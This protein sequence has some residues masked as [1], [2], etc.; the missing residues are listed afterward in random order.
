M[1]PESRLKNTQQSRPSGEDIQPESSAAGPVPEPQPEIRIGKALVPAEVD[2]RDSTVML[3]TMSLGEESIYLAPQKTWSQLDV[4]KWRVQGKL[5]GTPAGLEIT[6]DYVKVGGETVSISEP[7]GAEKL[8]RVFAK[9]MASE[10]EASELAK[11]KARTSARPLDAAPQEEDQIRFQVEMDKNGQ[12]RI[13]CLEGKDMVADVALTVPGLTSLI[14]QGFMRKPG[15]WKIGALRNWIELDG[16]LFKFQSGK[17]ETARLEQALN[18]RYAP[19][20]DPDGAPDVQVFE[21]AASTTGFDIQFPTLATGLAENRRRHLDPEAMELLSDPH[22]SRVLR[23]GIVVKLTPP[24]FLFKQQLPDGG[25]RPLEPGPE[26][27]VSVVGN[28]GVQ[29]WI[30]LSEP[31]SHIGLGQAELTAIFNHPAINRRAKLAQQ[32]QAPAG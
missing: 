21:N 4:Y 30:D 2:G 18:Q 13:R 10:K 16:E 11:E 25:E 14:T 27:T 5:P 12:P 19:I 32:A 1:M 8:E 28:D 17:N 29:K 24:N 22:R 31:V 20:A 15:S 7:E 9:W 6:L 3:F 26:A 23:K